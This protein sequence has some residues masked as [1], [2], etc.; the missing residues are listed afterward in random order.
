MPT[1]GDA[2]DEAPVDEAPVAEAPVA[3]PP[4]APPAPSPPV[5]EPVPPSPPAASFAAT[6]IGFPA[7]SPLPAPPPPAPAPVVEPAFRTWTL[8]P[9]PPEPAVEPWEPATAEATVAPAVEPW[10]PATE[11]PPVEAGPAEP[12]ADADP[13]AGVTGTP[14]APGVDTMADLWSVPD[15]EDAAPAGAGAGPSGGLFDLAFGEFEPV[16]DP[17]APA[18]GAATPAE[19]VPV[20]DDGTDAATAPPP[21]DD[22]PD[23]TAVDL[24]AF[25]QEDWVSVHALVYRPGPEDEPVPAPAAEEDPQH[26]ADV[27][28]AP[29]APSDPPEEPAGPA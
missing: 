19:V 10:E 15:T 14:D 26:R 18:N 12:V 27:P 20:T 29:S 8:A 17:E 11:A 3:P 25:E 28:S 5:S 13:G 22:V 23:G 9:T 6:P 7:A 4:A 1:D 24:E 16:A 21:V 2:P